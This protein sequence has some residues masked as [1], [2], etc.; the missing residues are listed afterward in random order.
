METRVCEIADGIYR[1][2][3]FVPEIAPPA[4]FTFNQFLIDADEP[5]LFHCGPR[6]MFSSV[7]AAVAEVL[8]P[9][10]LRWIAFGHVE[11]DECGAMNAW[12]AAAP[13]AVVAHGAIGCMVSL[14]D[15]ADR[16]PRALA[17][18]EMIDLGGKRVRHIDTPHVPHAWEA[19]LLYEETT[20]TLLCGDLF[21]HIGNGPAVTSTDIVGPAAATED[22]FRSTCLT[23]AT[24]PTIRRLAA[25]APRTLALMH[26]SSFA[27]DTAGALN[28]LADEYARRFAQ[29]AG[30]ERA[31]RVAA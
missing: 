20:G 17:D 27:G 16:P 28:A 1:L 4:G 15:L 24:A 18:G 9:E 31:G 7:S 19:R 2:S 21:A 3:T 23:P 10:R 25:L 5:L 30:A 8:R 14:N 29:A 11:S 13:R 26:G 22:A 12:L 6:A